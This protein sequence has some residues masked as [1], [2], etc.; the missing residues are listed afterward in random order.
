MYNIRYLFLKVRKL[1]RIVFLMF[2]LVKILLY[3]IQKL[4][5]CISFYQRLVS[6][7]FRLKEM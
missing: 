7:G 4:L 6:A 5:F 3:D 1:T 2:W